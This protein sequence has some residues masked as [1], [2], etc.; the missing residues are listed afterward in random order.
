MNTLKI[1]EIF[2]SIQ[3]ESTYAGMPCTFIRLSNCNL[4]C[5]W[6]DTKYSFSNG[7]DLSEDDI[8]KKVQNFEVKLVEITGGEPL[9]QK[10]KVIELSKKLNKLGFK[11]L[12]ETNGSVSLSDIPEYIIKIT[13]IKMPGSGEYGSFLYK[14]LKYVNGKDNIKFVLADMNDYETAK[15]LIITNGL[16]RFCEVLVSVASD[17]RNLQRKVAEQ[18]VKDKLK[19]RFQVQLHKILW[20]GEEQR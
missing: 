6:C 4:N 14:N 7:I 8:I 3:G 1:C 10:E 13:D 20:P 5:K 2:C 9:L 17:D 18:I 12:L 19:A 15:Q 11:I 16:D